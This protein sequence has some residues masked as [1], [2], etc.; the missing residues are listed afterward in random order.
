VL[1]KADPEKP[2]QHFINKLLELM[3]FTPCESG[4][5]LKEADPP[6]LNQPLL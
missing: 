3:N 6:I 2:N 5:K 4:L 1:K